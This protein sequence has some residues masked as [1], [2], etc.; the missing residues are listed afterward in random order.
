ML[1]T[2]KDTSVD[3]D[4]VREVKRIKFTIHTVPAPKGRPRFVRM[5]KFVKTYTPKETLVA[6]NNVLAQAIQHKPER[7]LEHRASVELVFLMSIPKGMTK[8]DRA[9]AGSGIFM[10]TKKPDIDNLGKT[11]LDALNG[12][13]WRDDS[14]IWRLGMVKRYAENPGIEVE[15]IG[16]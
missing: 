4:K 5:G 6:E 3:I 7:P 1:Y 15:I 9:I 11:V 10:H 8:R 12:V 2:G 16:T 14:I 13:F